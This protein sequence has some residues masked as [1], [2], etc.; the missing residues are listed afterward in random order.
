MLGI[1]F[2]A[3][4]SLV[5]LGSI[6]LLESVTILRSSLITLV[7]GSLVFYYSLPLIVKR[8]N[9]LGSGPEKQLVNINL[10][11]Y[12]V[13]AITFVAVAGYGWYASV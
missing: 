5:L 11:P 2:V 10:V 13:F 7:V 3:V 9:Y 1:S 4:C 12:M 6:W 8:K